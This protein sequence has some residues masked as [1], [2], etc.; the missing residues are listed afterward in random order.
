MTQQLDAEL[1]ELVDAGVLVPEPIVYEDFLPRSA[2]GIFQSNLSDE[3]SRDEDRTAPR[4]DSAWLAD[5]L[6][7]MCWTPWT[8]TRSS[9]TPRS[10][11]HGTARRRT[12]THPTHHPS[13]D[14]RGSTR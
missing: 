3:G 7:A 9:R 8:S 11:A 13:D 14:H 6:G 4:Y 10:R 5:A 1:R 12:P 2:A